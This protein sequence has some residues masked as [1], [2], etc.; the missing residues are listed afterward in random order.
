VIERARN[1]W[2]GKNK[3]ELENLLGDLTNIDADPLND[4]GRNDATYR[5]LASRARRPRVLCYLN[6][7]ES[8]HYNAACKSG[9]DDGSS[10]YVFISYTRSQFFVNTFD[11]EKLLQ[12]AR[13]DGKSEE[14]LQQLKD[15][16]GRKNE[17]ASRD[18]EVL[19]RLGVQ[20]ARSAGVPAFW[21]DFEGIPADDANAGASGPSAQQ[22]GL[23]EDV[24][25]ICDVLRCS[26]SMAVINGP[27]GLDKGKS[28]NRQNWREFKNVW[29]SRMWVLPELLLSPTEHRVSVYTQQKGVAPEDMVPEEIA[30][31]NLAEES[32]SDAADVQHL[33]DHFEGS[34]QLSKLELM[35]LAL[36]CLSRREAQGR[37][38]A[39]LA[40][41]LKGLLGRRPETVKDESGFEAFASLSLAND[42]QRLLERLICVLPI[43]PD[44]EWYDMRDGWRMKLWDL[45]PACQ[46]A[47]IVDDH[48]V[49]VDGAY[50]ASIQWNRLETVPFVKRETA[51]RTVA[52][53]AVRT[54]PIYF[55]LSL[56]WVIP[57]ASINLGGPNL[58][59]IM[60][61]IVLACACLVI[62]SAPYLLWKIYLGK[63]WST[64]AWFFGIEGDVDL[65]DVE[66]EL[67]GFSQ[68]RLKWSPNG[69]L[70]SNHHMNEETKEC[71]GDT[72]DK[73]N[74][75]DILG[76]VFS[77]LTG[78]AEAP[79]SYVEVSSPTVME[80]A[81]SDGVSSEPPPVEK[82]MN[83]VTT[84][85]GRKQRR[86][87][88]IDTYTM[89]ATPFYAYHPP[90]SV[91]ICGQEG[92][93]QRAVLCSYD[94]KAQTYCRETVVRMK[95]MVLERMFRVDRFRFAFHRKE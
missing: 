6:N 30:K 82:T 72:P 8:L 3:E 15:E 31:R 66:R 93:M 4:W 36:D 51:F 79:A 33:I 48:T 63:F 38:D 46:V 18:R 49:L 47:G 40:Y 44:A 84:T 1:K 25:L 32:C 61:G 94:W 9:G 11:V 23:S 92:G 28:W 19:L 78:A 83:Q 70:L 88:L 24:Y 16:L 67:F 86:F 5:G 35:Q 90:T 55:V 81:E 39:D 56:I 20:A 73:T 27:L 12:Q 58:F 21:I 71:E 59:L 60:G 26:H 22:S 17:Y 2:P 54:S 7:G 50:G 64:Q 65:R 68:N 14:E 89:T 77:K 95:T 91:L 85:P 87:T 69:S 53:I 45:E 74:T 41:A 13:D 75:K 57:S 29:A 34:I 10:E 62:L 76:K 80:T 37:T 42:S 43:N 52:K